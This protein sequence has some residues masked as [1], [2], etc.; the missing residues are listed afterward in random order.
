MERRRKFYVKET[1][2]KAFIIKY[3]LLLVIGAIWANAMLYL[4]EVRQ[5]DDSLYRAHIRI[6]TTGDVILTPL[7]FI[8]GIVLAGAIIGLSFQMI[9]DCRNLG[10]KIGHLLAALGPLGEGDLTVKIN[11]VKCRLLGDLFQIFNNAAEK[12]NG[13]TKSINNSVE[14]IEAT[15]Q[16]D[17][18]YRSASAY[19][20]IREIERIEKELATFRF[21]E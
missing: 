19:R 21:R 6:S 17:G 10:E 5:I 11:G 7:F 4:Y 12:L 18:I 9:R 16:N 8:N 2:Q 15:L 1:F 20:I 14:K 3:L 13:R